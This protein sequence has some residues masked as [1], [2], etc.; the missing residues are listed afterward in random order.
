[1]KKTFELSGENCFHDKAEYIRL[2]DELFKRMEWLFSQGYTLVSM[3]A[4]FWSITLSVLG[5]FLTNRLPSS[6]PF[7]FFIPLLVVFLVG[8][9]AILVFPFSVKYQ[10]SLRTVVSLAAYL[11]VFYELPSMLKKKTYEKNR[12][13]E[14]QHAIYAWET[15]H[16]D[17]HFERTRADRIPAGQRG[18]RYARAC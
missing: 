17:T 5:T 10:D 11:R 7:V 15:L 18:P 12:N 1:M 14:K 9:P 13:G 2:H 3:V 4:V 8:L 6:S 16:C